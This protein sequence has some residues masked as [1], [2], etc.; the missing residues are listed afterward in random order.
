M[1]MTTVAP[2]A[3]S[4]SLTED[5]GL[6]TFP[7]KTAKLSPPLMDQSFHTLD[8]R[9]RKRAIDQGHCQCSKSRISASVSIET[10]AN[11]IGAGDAALDPVV[12]G[13]GIGGGAAALLL[14]GGAIG[15]WFLLRSRRR[16][17]KTSQVGSMADDVAMT[18]ARDSSAMYASPALANEPYSQGPIEVVDESNSWSRSD[19]STVSKFY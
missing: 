11:E 13:A 7:P 18:S 15:L 10:N 6:P 16:E 2:T 8:P 14:V 3:T 9:I 1:T 4:L 19:G 12:L 5:D 17:K